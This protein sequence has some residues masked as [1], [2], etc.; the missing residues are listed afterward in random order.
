MANPSAESSLSEHF[1]HSLTTFFNPP[2]ASTS[3]HDNVANL[4]T[5]NLGA[6]IILSS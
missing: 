4:G 1:F 5:A 2:D 6:G 3:I